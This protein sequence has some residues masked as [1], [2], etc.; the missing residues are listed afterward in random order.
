MSWELDGIDD[1]SFAEKLLAEGVDWLAEL[2]GCPQ[3][4]VHHG[5][6]DVLIHVLMVC[7]ELSKL[8][9]FRQLPALQQQ[10]LAWAA[11]L[12]DVAKPACTIH[13]PDGRIS[14]P[15]HAIKG[16]NKARRLLWMKNCPFAL[17]E[18]I[19]GIIHYHMKVF[20]AFEQD[21]PTRLAREISLRCRCHHLAIL[22]E[23]DARGRVCPDTQDLLDR[24]ALFRELADEAGCLT[25]PAQFASNFCRFR[26]LEGKWHNPESPPYEDFK[27]RVLL[28]S[29]LPG[30]G[31]DTWLERR[32]PN[33]P[34]VS[35][36]AIREELN[37]SPTDNQGKVIE[38]AR[39][40]ARVYL[41]TGRNFIWNATN[42]SSR[43]R[44]KS[45]SLFLEYGAHVEIVYLEQD[46]QV[47]ESHNRDRPNMVPWPAVERMLGKWEVPT[48]TEAHKVRYVVVD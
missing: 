45:L 20:W 1:G 36:D 8:D 7:R 31:K 38:A 29:G 11:L 46:P 16:A 4:P 10:I 14:S 43:I 9:S 42:I 12:H 40:R 5:E 17:R 34:V 47:L 15:G 39:E 44:A 6:G 24:V 3:D 25:T 2:R 26:Y 37:I 41:R 19:C 35:L 32:G 13:E 48:L 27:C 22:A 28:M 21:D 23:A 33:W 18:E 30:S